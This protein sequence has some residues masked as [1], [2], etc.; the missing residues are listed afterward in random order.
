MAQYALVTGGNR[1]IGLALCRQLARE[2]FV[3]ALGARDPHKGAQAAA[4]LAGEG[5]PV[6]F[7]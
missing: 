5:L 3:V 7:Q 4:Q 2:G 1:G 6:Q